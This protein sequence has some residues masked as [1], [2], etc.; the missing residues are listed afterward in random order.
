M[1]GRISLLHDSDIA[2]YRFLADIHV[3]GDTEISG[4]APG[5][6]VGV[7]DEGGSFL[8]SVQQAVGSG[9][10]MAVQME[11]RYYVL[12]ELVG[13][14]ATEFHVTAQEEMAPILLGSVTQGIMEGGVIR[15]R[16]CTFGVIVQACLD[17]SF[18][19]VDGV[20]MV[21]LNGYIVKR[22]SLPVVA[23]DECRRAV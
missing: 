13:V 2:G 5:S 12:I 3:S 15:S 14:I 20:V 16:T 8:G 1:C 19:E 11:S 23:E 17:R 4:D 21:R 10:G 18:T 9:Y 22:N 7:D 6:P